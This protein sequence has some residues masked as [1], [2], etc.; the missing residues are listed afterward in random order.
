MSAV[1]TISHKLFAYRYRKSFQFLDAI[2]HV[3]SS[4]SLNIENNGFII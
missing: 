4:L 2:L 3:K 1:K